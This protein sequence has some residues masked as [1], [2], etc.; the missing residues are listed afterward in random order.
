MGQ[1]APLLAPASDLHYVHLTAMRLPAR[2]LLLALLP[3]GPAI[4][5][6]APAGP[7]VNGM[8]VVLPADW[9]TTPLQ[10]D[11]VPPLPWSGRPAGVPLYVRVTITSAALDQPD[12]SARRLGTLRDQDLVP[13]LLLDSPGAGR[14]MSTALGFDL[15]G[16]LT[17]VD[18]L[19]QVM[20]HE[21]VLVQVMER[22]LQHMTAPLY[23]FVLKRMAVMVRAVAP[24]S[25]IASGTLADVSEA[26]ELAVWGVEPYLDAV[27]M[28]R[29][30]AGAMDLAGVRMALP[31][32][33]IWLSGAGAGGGSYLR[34]AG[35]AFSRAVSLVFAA[36]DSGLSPEMLAAWQR[37]LG[38]ETI[39]VP[40]AFRRVE[41]RAGE[42]VLPPEDFLELE[43][44]DGR[45]Y[46]VAFAAPAGLPLEMTIHGPRVSVAWILDPVTGTETMGAAADW[47]VAGGDPGSHAVSQVTL[48]VPGLPLV[49]RLGRV[50]GA[51]PRLA[52]LEE[53]VAGRSL[54]VEEI[55]ARHR[56]VQAGQDRRLHTTE[57]D[58]RI[59]FHFSVANLSQRFDVATL[60]RYFHD[61]TR[62]VY[63]ERALYLNGALWRG[64]RPPDLPF[65]LPERV[66]EVPL[67]LNLDLR[68]VYELEKTADLDGRQ[69]YVVSFAPVEGSEAPYRGRVWIDTQ[70]FVKRR[71]EVV[72]LHPKLPVISNRL[73]QEFTPVTQ[74]GRTWWLVTRLTGQMIFT[75]LGRNVVLEREL[76][77]SDY[78]INLPAFE[79]RLD[80]SYASDRPL[81]EE[82]ED[83]FQRLGVVAD[84][85]GGFTRQVS[86]QGRTG[87][88]RL[89]VGVWSIGDDLGL[90]VP[91]AGVNYFNFD[92]RGTG[93]QVDVIWA[94]PFLNVFWSDPSFGGGKAILALQGRINPLYSGNERLD[95]GDDIDGEI[96]AERLEES[97][98]RFQIILGRPLGVHHKFEFQLDLDHLRFRSEDETAADFVVPSDTWQELLTGRWI[99][100]RAG[101]RLEGS[102][103]GG[104]RN[105][106]T[107]WGD[108]D[109]SDFSDGDEQFA[110]SAME[111]SK[112]FYSAGRNKFG[113]GLAMYHG[114]GLDRFSKFELGRSGVARVPG[115][116]RDGIRFRT[117]GVLGL[118]G[119]FALGSKARMDL[120]LTH[121]RFRDEEDLGP[122]VEHA[123]GASVA[124]NFSG[125]F[126]AF[127]RARVGFALSSS[128]DDADG[129]GSLR[130]TYFRTFRRWFWQR[131]SEKKHKNGPGS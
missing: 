120:S 54:T 99:Y 51:A 37:L 127:M 118:S 16:W 131:A 115:Y 39:V 10:A 116:S 65:V 125:P 84:G 22:P 119:A 96:K 68:Y 55:L 126:N 128:V 47:L 94:G 3:M 30:A 114:N 20:D 79:D 29:A 34:E 49:V 105:D 123:T 80:E 21:P 71:Q 103:Q 75:A 113:F 56:E 6:A 109:G 111:F 50:G 97:F 23:A 14:P 86:D 74:G 52:E 82:T 87:V 5:A 9:L 124:L 59:D 42:Q 31:A 25:H 81:L 100:A 24:G 77:Y 35:L 4:F 2:F 11:E 8:G 63:E 60:N 44:P 110:R 93:N 48:H 92:W 122:H 57:A 112:A 53:V 46:L 15:D 73:L 121:A 26:R 106:W 18:R 38:P 85:R 1:W 83:G 33:E 32:T 70:S 76:I 66:T 98:Q 69:V 17:R 89:V 36:P 91:F 117:G 78:Q 27:V 12:V 41:V 88:S 62:T 13:V 43:E 72:E 129:G 102:L 104:S 61:S 7:P 90:K 108:P 101:W 64:K 130:V 107:F 95:A 28:D 45:R 58:V 40:P 19:L 67:D